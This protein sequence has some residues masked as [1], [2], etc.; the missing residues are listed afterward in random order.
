MLLTIKPMLKKT[1]T[2]AGV[3]TVYTEMED[4]SRIKGLKYAWVFVAEPE[5]V[6]R[7]GSTIVVKDDA[8]YLREYELRLK[9]GVRI[10]ARDELDAGGIKTLFL[11]ALALSSTVKDQHGF[12]IEVTAIMAEFVSDKSILKTGYGYEIVIEFSGGVY[13]PADPTAI[14]PWLKTLSDWAAATLGPP[15]RSYEFYPVGR[16]DMT[17]YWQVSSVDM[18]DKGL[19]MF[20]VRKKMTAHIFAR[21]DQASWAAAKIVEALEAA[22]KIAMNAP[23]KKYLTAYKPEANLRNGPMSGGQVSVTLLRNTVRPTT[24]VPLIGRVSADGKLQE[25]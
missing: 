5:R 3:A 22:H 21:G 25:G 16:P 13:R 6:I 18:E 7:D 2:S 1:L 15:W 17:L 10:A 8:H 24:E 23:Q 19:A 11:N 4:E 12:D 9:V 14:D 20:T